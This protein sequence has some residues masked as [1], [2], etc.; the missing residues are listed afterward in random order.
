M[1]SNFIKIGI[2]FEIQF[3]G[4]TLSLEIPNKPKKEKDIKMNL[5]IK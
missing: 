2:I 4:Y 3:R 1:P 5:Q